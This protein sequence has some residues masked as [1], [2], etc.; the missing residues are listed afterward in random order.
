[1][2]V[3]VIRKIG[4]DMNDEL[5]ALVIKAGAP[6]PLLDEIWFNI[7][8]EQFADV[9]LTQAETEVFGETN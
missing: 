5:K 8:C 1:M 4:V 9:L 3:L 7:F 6:A 2:K